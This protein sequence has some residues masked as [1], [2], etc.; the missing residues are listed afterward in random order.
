[1]EKLIELLNEWERERVNHNT[2][3]YI[4]RGKNSFT[5]LWIIE[6]I[7]KS[8]WFIE[9]LV[10]NDKI[11]LDMVREKLWIPCCVWYGSWRIIAVKDVEDYKQVLMLLSISDTP[12]EDLISY[13]K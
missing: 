5:R 4:K 10:N 2:K 13:L 9:W 7:S 8:Y 1:M 12:I 6:V 11:D 3:E